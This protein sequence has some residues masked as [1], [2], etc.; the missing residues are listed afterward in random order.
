[1][2]EQK[3]EYVKPQMTVVEMVEESCLL[4][5]SSDPEDCVEV[6]WME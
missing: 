3:K 6:E 4:C 1:M 5:G 2:N